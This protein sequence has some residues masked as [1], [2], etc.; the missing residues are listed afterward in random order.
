MVYDSLTCTYHIPVCIPS[1]YATFQKIKVYVGTF[2]KLSGREVVSHG[3]CPPVRFLSKKDNLF[4]IIVCKL[5]KKLLSLH[6]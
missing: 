5:R 1:V 2:F 3:A 6:P 4:W